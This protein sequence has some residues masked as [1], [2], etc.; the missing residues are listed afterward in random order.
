MAT[1]FGKRK[2][3][4]GPTTYL[5]GRVLYFD[6]VEG[7]HWDPLTDFYVEDDEVDELKALLFKKIAQ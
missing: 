4:D 6:P 3:L 1:K 5:N 7:K 2:G